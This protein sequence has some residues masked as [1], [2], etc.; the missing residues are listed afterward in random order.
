MSATMQRARAIVSS[1]TSR[2][3]GKVEPIETTVTPAGSDRLAAEHALDL[4]VAA[5]VDSVQLQM[6]VV[7][8]GGGYAI[9]SMLPEPVDPRL[10]AARIVDPT[11]ERYVV[12]VESPRRPHTRATRAVKALN[13]AQ[14]SSVIESR[15][16]TWRQ[17]ASAALPKA[18]SQTWFCT[19][20]CSVIGFSRAMA[21]CTSR[22]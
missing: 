13:D 6:E 8:H 19:W 1:S 2:C 3:S 22:M 14:Y 21:A 16:I 7:A 17:V 12:L 15:L 9:A 20:R 11:L 10:S 5:E 18:L 4:Q